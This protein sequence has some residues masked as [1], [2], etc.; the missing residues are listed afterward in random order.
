MSIV[1]IVCYRGGFKLNKKPVF[2]LSLSSLKG[3]PLE[4][5]TCVLGRFWEDIWGKIE[6]SFQKWYEVWVKNRKV[7][8]KNIHIEFSEFS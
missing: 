5:N 1:Q 3:A 2:K 4:V 8:Y 7:D 6:V